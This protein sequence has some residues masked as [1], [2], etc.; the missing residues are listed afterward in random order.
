[1]PTSGLL[2]FF[3]KAQSLAYGEK[4]GTSNRKWREPIF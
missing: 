2:C 4:N 1:M 3:Q